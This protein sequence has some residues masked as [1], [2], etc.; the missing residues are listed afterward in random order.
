MKVVHIAD[1]HWRGLKRHDEYRAVFEKLFKEARAEKPDR[2]VVA[3][4]IVHSKTQGITPELIQHLV[5]W[6]TEMASIAPTIVT[7]G[8]HDGLILNKS[9]L[10]AISPIIEALDNPN[11]IFMRDSGVITEW[12]DDVPV[13]W[14]NFSCFDEEGWEKVK[15]TPDHVNIAL[16]HGAVWGAKTDSEW[17]LTEGE[18]DIRKFTE[19]DFGMFGDIHK[20]QLLDSAGRFA[21]PGSTI[22]QNFGEDIDKGYLVWDI[23]G[24]DSWTIKRRVVESPHPHVTVQWAGNVQATI[25]QCRLH[26]SG[27]RFRIAS[28]S[29][30]LQEEFKQLAGF[31]KEDMQAA[32]ITWK[33]DSHRDSG[34]IEIDTDLIEKESLRDQ[35]TQLSLLRQYIKEEGFDEDEWKVAE[36]L[37]ERNLA[38]VNEE[39]S[40]R[41]AKWSIKRMEW[42][43]T[44][45]YGKDN[46]IDFTKLNGVM[47]LFGPNRSGKSS[48]P[49]SIM[50]GLYNTTD[51]GSIK[52]L[53]VVNARKGHC[54][55]T[56]DFGLNGKT[57]RVERM[58][59]KSTNK[60]GI[61]GAATHMNLWQLDPEGNPL[62]DM[63]GE[64]RRD[65][66][67]V[68]RGLI[69]TSEDFLL[70]SFA[71]QGEMNNFIKEKASA[72][73]MYLSSFLDLGVFDE[74]FR[75]LKDESYGLKGAMK[76]PRIDYEKTISDSRTELQNLETKK[77]TLKSEVSDS[78]EKIHDLNLILA[79]HKDKGTVTQADVDEAQRLLTASRSK[80]EE[81][82]LKVSELKETLE[83][84]E[85]K[86]EKIT[87]LKSKFP[88]QTLRD[89]L[90]ELREL[91][92][93][94][95]GFDSA[96][97]KEKVV[98]KS[99][100]KSASRL[101]EV[102]CGD[103][104]PSCKFIKDSH[105]DKKLI[106]Q[107]K[108]VIADL[109]EQ[110]KDVSRQV[111][112]LREK[113]LE[114]KLRRYDEVL[115]EEATLTVKVK[116][117]VT[118]E[119]LL[120]ESIS[121]LSS[122]IAQAEND[123]ASM[124]L[125]VVDSE[126]SN[127][128]DSLKRKIYEIQEIV[129]LK[130]AEL[131]TTD[132]NCGQ[133]LG[134]IESLIAE[135][136]SYLKARKEWRI[137]EKLLAA[138]GKNGIPLM[139]L[140]TELPKINSEISKILHGVT[141]FTVILEADPETNDLEVYLDYG[142]SQRPI[143]LGSGMEKMMASLAIRV[144]LINISSLPKTD[145]LVIDEGFGALDDANVEACNR[146]L[147]ALKRYFKAILVISHVDGVKEAVDGMIEIGRE[148]KDSHV[149]YV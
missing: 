59:T 148:G 58:T 53:H 74:M 1:V 118:E 72:R 96:L 140:A 117:Y 46:V 3:G 125:R 31:L 135:Q 45:T 13:A 86:L 132:R 64:Q 14:C 19:F 114:E 49:G 143:E 97:E 15:P 133:L 138:Y 98:L 16:F 136:D 40:P 61:T 128:I 17:E 20:Y 139:I 70:T 77:E 78:R 69:G 131:S 122:K 52:N 34:T 32:E 43:N 87:A 95:S 54:T 22:Q 65:S 111:T 30:L 100:E 44:F 76:S 89:E 146:L 73:K 4:D 134:R 5:W 82:L 123:I 38:H 36:K 144:A 101:A 103:S 130:E 24:K 113:A 11:I 42:E 104:Y 83:K 102:P 75:R 66:D 91:E 110:M 25:D 26:R 50:Y 9:R 90:S 41:H 92:K 27:S 28:N 147:S 141:G 2:I 149:C 84:S 60:R 120:Q 21:Y 126:S 55:V 121:S 33:I 109:Q 6:F 106:E 85:L 10:D 29:D 63:S 116:S 67:K 68:L 23:K 7:L 105:R 112:S 51:R 88:L 48:I 18:V 62:I 108:K 39:E 8:N 47:G 129:K 57:Y 81:N 94:E 56:I 127:E 142:D 115:R 93:R 124:K 145:I 107:Q 80:R 71:S 12:V 137:Y 35:K 99:Q 37:I 119:S 79:T